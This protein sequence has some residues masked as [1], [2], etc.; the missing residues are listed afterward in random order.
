MKCLD[1]WRNVSGSEE[2]YKKGNDIFQVVESLQC[3]VIMSLIVVSISQTFSSLI[4]MLHHHRRLKIHDEVVGDDK[5]VKTT[6]VVDDDRVTLCILCLERIS[7]VEG[8]RKI[9]VAST[10]LF[11]VKSHQVSLFF[12]FT[13]LKIFNVFC[14]LCFIL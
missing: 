2:Y 7:L 9:Y 13:S 3:L 8:R 1:S 5:G 12:F 11:L 6:L 10:A 4:N 14:K